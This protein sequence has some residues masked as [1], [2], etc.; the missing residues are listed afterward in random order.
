MFCEYLAA[1]ISSHFLTLLL[2]EPDSKAVLLR[3]KAVKLFSLCILYNHITFFIS[4]LLRTICV[5]YLMLLKYP[6]I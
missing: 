1:F 4:V 5:W 3:Q 2:C 6:S